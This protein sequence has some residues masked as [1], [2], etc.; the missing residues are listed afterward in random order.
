MNTEQSCSCRITSGCFTWRGGEIGRDGA[1][2][3]YSGFLLKAIGLLLHTHRE[4]HCRN[5]GYKVC[6]SRAAGLNMFLNQSDPGWISAD[7]EQLWRSRSIETSRVCVCKWEEIERQRWDEMRRD[8]ASIQ[9]MVLFC[10]QHISSVRAW[11]SL[12]ITTPAIHRAVCVST[13]AWTLT[14]H[15]YTLKSGFISLF[16]NGLFRP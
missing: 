11:N 15:I 7:R 3:Y 6:M 14:A 16:N 9:L 12:L 5:T 13:E 10:L 8:G 2:E 1:R 4:K